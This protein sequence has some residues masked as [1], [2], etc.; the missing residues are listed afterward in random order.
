M[1]VLAFALLFITAF[2]NKLFLPLTQL[3]ETIDRVSGQGFIET[4][5]IVSNDEVGELAAS[6]NEMGQRVSFARQEL[7]R[8][9][10][11]LEDI[12]K[13]RTELLE[14]A[15]EKAELASQAKSQFLANMSHEIRTPMNAIIGFS[16][17]LQGTSL[18]DAQK[19]YVDTI[20]N[21]SDV[22]LSLI[23]DILD[24][25]KIEAQSLNLEKISFDLEYLIG[26]LLKMIKTRVQ[27]KTIELLFEFLPGTPIFYM[28]DPT[29]IR[30]IVLNL[31][32]NASKFTEQ[33]EIKVTVNAL[34]PLAGLGGTQTLEISVKDT[35]IGVPLDK[36]ESIFSLF[37]QADEST[38]RKFG[39]TGLGLSIA[40]AL[41]QKMDGD[42]KVFS[43]LGHGSEFIVTLQ[44]EVASCVNGQ[45]ITLGNK[46]NIL[47]HTVEELSLK[48]VRVLV[49]EDQETNQKLMKVFMDM[50]G[51][52]TEYANNGQEA[53]EKMKSNPY[54][55][56]LMDLQMPVMGGVEATR[57][58]RSEINKEIP[59]IA[60]T[61]AAMKEDEIRALGSGMSD[62]LTK[63]IDYQELKELL[64]K[65]I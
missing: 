41:A 23:S 44:L 22:L 24:I 36:Q 31:L 17:I 3:K 50:F 14:K 57:I 1:S 40:R 10:G 7:A 62:Y 8:Y 5:D 32:S 25:S 63:P 11:H 58:I 53:I 34:K 43:E 35:G 65:W 39:G 54:D 52:V 27:N 13:E 33:G 46:E 60:L 64:L 37:T 38:T 6:F 19:D 51:C 2:L 47:R 45:E 61:A 59:I 48:G 21:S 12:V 15:R 49:V 26:S 42:I 55:V 16:D 18:D 56:C 4:V 9:Q 29:R 30:Q 28:G 20:M